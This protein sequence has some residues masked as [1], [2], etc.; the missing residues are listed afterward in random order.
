MR[1]RGRGCES[2]A[3]IRVL[4]LVTDVPIIAP[5]E[6][7]AALPDRVFPTLPGPVQ[8][9]RSGLPEPE[10]RWVVELPESH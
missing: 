5:A 3:P 9:V 4:D 7:V 10:G 1:R 2:P 8:E 6:L